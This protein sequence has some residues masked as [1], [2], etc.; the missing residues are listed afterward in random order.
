MGVTQGVQPRE[1]AVW[2]LERGAPGGACG[3]QR[4]GRLDERERGEE[5]SKCVL[6]PPPEAA[7]RLPILLRWEL[8]LRP[9]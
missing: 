7:A 8:R 2:G 3:K 9:A 4:S 5:S 1:R 6:D